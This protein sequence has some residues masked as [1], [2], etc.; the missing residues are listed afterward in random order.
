MKNNK[1]RL[2]LFRYYADRFRNSVIISVFT[3]V[4]EAFH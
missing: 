4:K 3:G 1:N 2:G